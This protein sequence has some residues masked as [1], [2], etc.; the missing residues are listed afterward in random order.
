MDWLSHIG[1]FVVACAVLVVP[2]GLIAWGLGLR[3]FTALA[4]AFPFSMVA[5]SATALSN[6]VF[7]FDWSAWP[8][9]LV[10][11]I[12]LA[13]AILFRWIIAR[14]SSA[15]RLWSQPALPRTALR[16]VPFA[17][18][19]IAVLC[20]VPRLVWIF[21]DPG[22]ISQTFD[23]IYHLNGIRY[24]LDTGQAAP[25]K[26]LIPGFYP[27]AWHAVVALVVQMTSTSIP[28]AVNI[29]SIVLGA[30]AW[31][32]GCVFFVRQ[33]VG[34]RPMTIIA[35]G[36]LAAGIGAFP[37][38]M[39][40]FG[41]L[42][43]N[44]LSIS[45]LPFALSAVLI[46]GRLSP[47][48]LPTPIAWSLLLPWIAALAL[49]HPSTLM[50]FFAIGFW[51]AIVGGVAYFRSAFAER[52]RSWRPSAAAGAWIAGL[53]AT[54]VVLLEARPTRAQ[55]FWP[56]TMSPGEAILQVLTN[57]ATGK[58]VALAASILM[59]AG[60]VS[61]LGWRRRFSWLVAS[62]ATMAFIYVVGV[63]FPPDTF[64]YG[65]TGTWYS[66]MVR[67][68][69]LLPVVV[70]PLAAIGFDA[71]VT[72]LTRMTGRSQD[73]RAV[74][75]AI[76]TSFTVIVLIATQFGPSMAVATASAKASYRM[77]SG[78][79][80]ITP[81]EA[82]LLARLPAHVGPEAVI[83]GSPWTGTSL[84]YALAD[85]R[86]L[87]PHIYQET[88]ADMATILLELDRAGDD[89]AVCDAVRRAG[90]GFVLDFGSVEV[91]GAEHLY[92]GL[93]DLEGSDNVELI[94]EEGD[95]RLYRI[96]ACG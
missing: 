11:A 7:V 77:D 81:D 17:A 15:E 45:I 42:Y 85:R 3:G 50:A 92:E 43:P 91:H 78:S 29:V 64:R 94:D 30:I 25:T 2:G 87:I 8:V 60:M 24:I 40:D 79:P 5:I 49:A 96:T 6:V 55:A 41:V 68:A 13:V 10:T 39:L 1:V 27:S 76:A 52:R 14:L 36:V 83:V 9:I 47:I 31:P 82:A 88:D 89:A 4:A 70:I 28:V 69:A 21:G 46:V 57:S 62:F 32:L 33:L 59:V 48:P 26:Q 86:A 37:I 90:V 20:L 63:S 23:N 19:G 56:P 80:L 72:A 65:L 66:D 58:P 44:V 71:I 18:V 12:L 22:A 75:V 84:S 54:T 35:T 61:I 67:V 51:P 34:D 95:A 93:A 74:R 53:G 16:W 38:L 73:R